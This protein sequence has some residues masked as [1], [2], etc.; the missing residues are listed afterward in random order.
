VTTNEELKLKSIR[1]T[2]NL[3]KL[4]YKKDDIFYV[5]SKNNEH[6]ASVIFAGALIGAPIQTNNPRLI[7]SIY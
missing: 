6:V 3:L 4:G 1:V 5:L 2:Q 7:T